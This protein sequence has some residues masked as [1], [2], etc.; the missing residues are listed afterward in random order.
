VTFL[1]D[2]LAAFRLTR[3]AVDDTIT[4]TPRVW[5]SQRSR[6]LSD[7]LA[8]YWCTGMW[9]AAGVSLA[10]TVAPR[11]W[12]WVARMLAVA[13]AVGLVSEHTE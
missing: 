13:A 1:V 10:R 11:Q 8:C 5:V 2:C 3:L 7:L 9:V 4:A 6:F 12:G